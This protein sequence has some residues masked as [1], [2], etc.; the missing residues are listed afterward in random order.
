MHQREEEKMVKAN[1]FSGLTL[2]ANKTFT[3]SCGLAL[4]VRYVP[5][6]FGF[7]KYH[8]AVDHRCT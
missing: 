2:S 3:D 8:L 1:R 5:K 4:N 7:E 6:I